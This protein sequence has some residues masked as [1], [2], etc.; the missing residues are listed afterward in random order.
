ME[1]PDEPRASRPVKVA[2]N[3]AA[4]RGTG[5]QPRASPVAS[6]LEG[7]AVLNV[8]RKAVMAVITKRITVTVCDVGGESCDS[9]QLIHCRVTV[10]KDS[11]ALD[12]CPEH[13]GPL[14][15]LLA[16]AGRT[17]RG[18]VVYETLEDA[19]KLAKKR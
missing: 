10:G 19:L 13:V 2:Q 3:H 14:R 9:A 8:E 16:A 4:L 6:G 18:P 5:R 12:L 11:A 17:S 7:A 15:A 1:G